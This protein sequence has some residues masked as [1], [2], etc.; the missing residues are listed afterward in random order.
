MPGDVRSAPSTVYT[1][2][3]FHRPHPPAPLASQVM[4]RA[5]M[6][7]CYTT[8]LLLCYTASTLYYYSNILAGPAARADAECDGA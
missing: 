8:T 1:R 4:L 2:L 7:H 6:L 3:S 5:P